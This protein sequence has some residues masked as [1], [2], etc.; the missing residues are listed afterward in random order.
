MICPASLL[1]FSKLLPTNTLRSCVV[2]GFG[3][4]VNQAIDFWDA[5]FGAES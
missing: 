3:N 5:D 1:P 2:T 4:A